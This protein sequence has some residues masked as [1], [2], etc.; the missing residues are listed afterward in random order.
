MLLLSFI[1]GHTAFAIA[2]PSPASILWLCIASTNALLNIVNRRGWIAD[3]ALV[4]LGAPSVV[5]PHVLIGNDEAALRGAVA[6]ASMFYYW[7]LVS[8]ITDPAIKPL[9]SLERVAHVQMSFHDI[10][11][12][13]EQLPNRWGR[14]ARLV[15]VLGV[16]AAM[17]LAGARLSQ[18]TPAGA[19]ATAAAAEAEAPTSTTRML[20][21]LLVAGTSLQVWGGLRAF[22]H[23]LALY[24]AFWTGRR[25]PAL[26]RSVFRATSLRDFWG[27]WSLSSELGSQQQ[28]SSSSSSTTRTSTS[29]ASNKGSSSSKL[30]R[31]QCSSLGSQAH[32][33]IASATLVVLTQAPGY[34]AL[35]PMQRRH[36]LTRRYLSLRV[37]HPPLPSASAACCCVL[38]LQA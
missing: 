11:T 17:V 25:V 30:S 35:R 34:Y 6:M 22:G 36:W 33:A 8:C 20:P 37:L 7:R 5:L 28:H 10:R 16:D 29:S 32:A 2:A 31:Q 23:V 21:V 9:P 3:A 38:L 4:V 12:C 19:G 26:M 14:V 18:E 13:R 15:V 27:A 1:G 24:F